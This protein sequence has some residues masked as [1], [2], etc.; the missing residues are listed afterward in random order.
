MASQIN[1]T[2]LTD[3]VNVH[4][5][6]LLT[7]ATVGGKT[8]EYV[9]IMGNVKYKD[10]LNYLDSTVVLGD[11]SACGF[12]PQGSD[13]FTE[14]FI[15][16]KPVKVEKEWC[17]ADWAKKFA[18]HQLHFEAG[19]ETLPFEQKMA[20]ANVDAIQE[21]V[22][23]LVWKGDSTLGIDGFK[24][25]VL[26]DGSAIEVQKDSTVT[27]T[28]DAIVGG[29]TPRMLKKGVDIFVSY[30]TF[31][32]YVQEQNAYCCAN[33]EVID[34][35]KDELVY[36]G[37]S[38]VRI[39]PTLGLEGAA[40]IVAASRENLVYGTDIEGSE[41]VYRLWYDENDDMFRFRVRFNAGTQIKYDDEVVFANL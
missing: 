24:A 40:I 8:L 20:E 35:A 7:K 11:G 36:A 1:V 32:A 9:D 18:N 25:Q 22:E 30:T 19:R 39:V 26:A 23:N 4:K 14:K 29:L 34:G 27:G 31:R 10:A 21:A 16:V 28:I 41:N 2:A 12:N 6:E 33:R 37:D 13:V 15:E 38:R 17:A 5:D 3:Y